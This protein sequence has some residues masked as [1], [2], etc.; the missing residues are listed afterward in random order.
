MESNKANLIP[1]HDYH[2]ELLDKLSL[3]RVPKGVS[4]LSTAFDSAKGMTPPGEVASFPLQFQ[5]L[6][7]LC[8]ELQREAGGKPF[9]LDGRSA[10]EKVGIPHSTA[11]SWL[12][13]LCSPRLGVLQEV[14]KGRTGKASRYKYLLP[15]P[16]Q[17]SPASAPACA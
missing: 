17:M 11:A 5:W 8:R 15:I 7:N 3:V 14:F 9:Y 16:T 1:N 10:A 13:A 12:R 2:L 6:V 4:P